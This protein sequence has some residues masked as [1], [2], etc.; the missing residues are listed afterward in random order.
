MFVGLVGCERAVELVCFLVTRCGSGV[1]V[2]NQHNLTP[3]VANAC[4]EKN[5]CCSGMALDS[6]DKH[7]VM[8]AV[9]E[10]RRR[11]G[12]ELHDDLG[13]EITGAALMV[14]ALLDDARRNAWSAELIQGLE[15][16]N[17]RLRR[18]KRLV[19]DLSHGLIKA[20]VDASM[21]Y[22]CLDE[23]AVQSSGV[24]GIQCHWQR[25]S[26]VLEI[27]PMCAT[28][29]YRIAQEAITNALKHSRASEVKISIIPGFIDKKSDSELR[30]QDNGICVDSHKSQHGMGLFSM[31]SRADLI[32]G[33][34]QLVSPDHS[35]TTV[36]CQFKELLNHDCE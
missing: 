6:T 3:W 28:H 5:V 13:Q 17:Q 34:L 31:Q 27:S 18:S 32:G 2:V 4:D 20:P 14:E 30:I 35:G 11:L 21:L 36:I 26:R 15:R 16:V 7:Q 9:E 1:K 8:A 25:P 23:L 24:N 10:Q 12:Q 22:E 29:L 33:K 19:R